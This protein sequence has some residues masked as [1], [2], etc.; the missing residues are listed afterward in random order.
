MYWMHGQQSGLSRKIAW[1][2]AFP[3]HCSV[4]RVFKCAL[5]AVAF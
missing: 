3:E 4:S 2:N 5:I 1:Q